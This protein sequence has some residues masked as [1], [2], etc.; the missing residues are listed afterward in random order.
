MRARL[1]FFALVSI[2]FMGWGCRPKQPVDR[3]SVYIGQLVHALS[4]AGATGI[5]RGLNTYKS[6][7]EQRQPRGNYE[8]RAS[9][10][11]A[12]ADEMAPFLKSNDESIRRSATAVQNS[13][14]GLANTARRIA[15]Y[16]DQKDSGAD[17][18][19][20]FFDFA[21]ETNAVNDKLWS[22]LEIDG[23][24]S[25]LTAIASNDHRVPISDRNALARSIQIELIAANADEA[26]QPV[27]F[28]AEIYKGL[29]GRDPNPMPH[30]ARAPIDEQALIDSASAGTVASQSELATAIDALLQQSLKQMQTDP[31]AGQRSLDLASART[32][33]LSNVAQR[34]KYFDMIA[35]RQNEA[36]LFNDAVRTARKM[37]DPIAR[38]HRVTTIAES[39]HNVHADPGFSYREAV[40]SAMQIP[41]AEARDGKLFEIAVSQNFCGYPGDAALT[42]D[43]MS[44]PAAQESARAR[45]PLKK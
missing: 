41:D 23:V 21:T 39:Q 14:R 10:Y 16:N 4:G 30:R 34:E 44:N 45:I 33:E 35:Y 11:T 40:D 1:N 13:F 2:A 20:S 28:L 12:A 3:P 24:Q 31:S 22:T 43:R 18:L 36:G 38:V 5:D 37:T 15:A 25:I 32:D 26:P 27:V 7:E 9:A 17:G 8:S 19:P 42:V 29:T 6:Y